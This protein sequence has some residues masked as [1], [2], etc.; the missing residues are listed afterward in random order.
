MVGSTIELRWRN[1]IR[2]SLRCW[3]EQSRGGSSPLLSTISKIPERGFL[4]SPLTLGPFSVIVTGFF[5]SSSA[6]LLADVPRTPNEVVM[7]KN[8]RRNKRRTR[9][10]DILFDITDD[11]VPLD[12]SEHPTSPPSGR[13]PAQCKM[14]SFID[15][16]F[17]AHPH[18]MDPVTG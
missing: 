8:S 13:L 11:D 1:G 2:T 15:G 9:T 7:S 6:V 12:V 3:R 17:T 4:N 16:L 10:P 14:D 5:S 18:D